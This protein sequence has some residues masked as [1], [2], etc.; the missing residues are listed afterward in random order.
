MGVIMKFFVPGADSEEQRQEIFDS[1]RKT[2]KTTVGW[3]AT[4]RKIYRLSYNHDGMEYM[5]TVGEM[6]PRTGECVT[7]ILDAIGMFLVCTPNSGVFRGEPILVGKK[8]VG[9]VVDFE[10]E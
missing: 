6:E 9:S 3:A 10:S 4:E 5:A 2:A 7:V 8:E 1:A